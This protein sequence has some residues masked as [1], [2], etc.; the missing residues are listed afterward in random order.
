MLGRR[1]GAYSARTSGSSILRSRLAS[2]QPADA[3]A[4][5]GGI[6]VTGSLSNFSLYIFHPYGGG[7]GQKKATLSALEN[8]FRKSAAHS[9]LFACFLS[10]ESLTVVLCG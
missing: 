2:G 1:P 10:C 4:M 3:S 9:G 7:G 5:D 8:T 6:S